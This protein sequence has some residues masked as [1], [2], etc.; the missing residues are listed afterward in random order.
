VVDVAVFGM[1]SGQREVA[2]RDAP[3]L[4][5]PAERS[6][7]NWG[8]RHHHGTA[9]SAIESMDG[10]DPRPQRISYDAHEISGVVR[11]STMH[12]EPGRLV[13]DDEARVTEYDGHL[14]GYRGYIIVSSMFV[15]NYPL[16]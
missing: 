10:I 2:F 8:E 15:L 9:G 11:E 6:R 4:E 14:H 12:D 3:L 1:A 5:R 16:A 13:D 7:R